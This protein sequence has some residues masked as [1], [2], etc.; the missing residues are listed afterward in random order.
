[1][2]LPRKY[3]GECR[4]WQEVDL[5]TMG[6]KRKFVASANAPRRLSK[7]AIQPINAENCWA[8]VSPPV[9]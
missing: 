7:A 5:V 1:M 6:G 8:I 9:L 2:R 4:L 3:C